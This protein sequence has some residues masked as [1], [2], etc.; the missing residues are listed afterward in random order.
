ML[1]SILTLTNQRLNLYVD[2]DTI[3]ITIIIIIKHANTSSRFCNQ[4][5]TATRSPDYG[6]Y[7]EG[8]P[9]LCTPRAERVSMSSKPSFGIPS[10]CCPLQVLM[11][12][13]SSLG[14]KKDWIQW[15]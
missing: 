3:I 15:Q 7:S 11:W 13:F 2:L 5:L 8:S 4:G 12:R 1:W 6:D 14:E 10:V 9:T